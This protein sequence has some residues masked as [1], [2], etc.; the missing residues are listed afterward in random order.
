M[1]RASEVELGETMRLLCGEIERID[2]TRIVIDSL[3]EMRLLAQN[4]P[5][6]RRQVF[7]LK[8]F[9]ESRHATVLMIDDVTSESHDFQLHSI[10][11]GVVT[12]QE[13]GLD[14][15]ARLWRGAATFVRDED[16]R[17]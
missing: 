9:L 7:A 6:Y 8:H 11:H 16:A 5:R 15:G 4:P 13:L 12:L 3:S 1:F 17:D 14:V 2:P 10:V